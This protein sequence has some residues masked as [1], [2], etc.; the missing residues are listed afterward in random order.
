[1]QIIVSIIALTVTGL[2]HAD[3]I[4]VA[5]VNQHF[6]ENRGLITNEEPTF[7]D[8]T[9][10][11]ARDTLGGLVNTLTT[12]WIDF[13][14][15]ERDEQCLARNIYYEAATESEEGKAAVGIVTINRVKEGRYGGNTIC[16]V[17][18]AR[19]VFVKTREVKEEIVHRGY[20]GAPEKSTQ[21]RVVV[22]SVPVCQFSWVCA[23]V[24][25]PQ[26]ADERWEESQR[27]AHELLAGGLD[28]YVAKYQNAVYFHAT[29][30]RPVWAKTKQYVNRIGGHI[31]Y[32]DL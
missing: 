24:R 12:P 13:Q 16:A 30:I 9:I 14:V 31:F 4:Q 21:T 6:F 3:E 1:M 23:F 19:T 20:F 11:K 22:T 7:V 8:R 10:N 29:G 17:V 26:V 32:A 5:P 18:N 27:I 28:Q 15:S 25:R 2:G